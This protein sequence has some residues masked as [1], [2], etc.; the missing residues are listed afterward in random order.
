MEAVVVDASVAIKW[1]YSEELSAHAM[2]LRERNMLIAPE[3]LV[4]E[5]GN[6]LW[7]KVRRGEF[8][9]EEAMIAGAA[10]RLA[11]VQLVPLAGLARGALRLSLEID[12]PAYDCFY[13]ELCRIRGIPLV[14]ADERLIRKLEA[15]KVLPVPRPIAL[16]AIS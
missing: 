12:H 1:V 7:K 15:V 11:Q 5:C 3:L 4:A 13:L 8:S 14:T 6:I 2:A 10:L 9:R 16:S